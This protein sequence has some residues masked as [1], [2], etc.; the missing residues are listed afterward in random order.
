MVDGCWGGLKHLH[1]GFFF[2]KLCLISFYSPVLT[3]SIPPRPSPRGCLPLPTSTSLPNP[4]DLKSLQLGTS[5]T[6]VKP[7]TYLLDISG[8]HTSSRMLPGCWLGV[9]EIS[10]VQLVKLLVF[11]WGYHPPEILPTFP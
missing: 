4:W 9:R 10:G 11:L 6:E 8:P 7:G 5:L 1:T 3:H 2:L